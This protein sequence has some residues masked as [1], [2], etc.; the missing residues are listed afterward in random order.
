MRLEQRATQGLQIAQVV[1]A[2]AAGRARRRGV[3]EASLPAPQGVRTDAKKLS[4]RVGSNAA[5]L[6]APLRDRRFSP[7]WSLFASGAAEVAAA[8]WRFAASPA[9]AEYDRHVA[10]SLTGQLRRVALAALLVAVVV[11]S[12]CAKE[13]GQETT[14]PAACRSGPEAIRGA[15]T[16]APGPVTIDGTPLSNCL[17]RAGDATDLQAV[18]AAYVDVAAELAPAARKD[19]GGPE[20]EQLGYLV[21][22]VRRAAARTQGIHTELLRRMEQELLVVDTSSTAFR[23]GERA[24]RE[25][26]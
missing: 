12:G 24:G 4:R 20:A 9:S 19:P 6:E 11:G 23:E 17:P 21:G 16:A 18:G 14:L 22:A 13:G 10:G 2:V 25:S 5:Q 7:L 8:T 15:L 3:A 1:L 26:G